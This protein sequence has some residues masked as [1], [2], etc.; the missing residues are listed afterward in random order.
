MLKAFYLFSACAIMLLVSCVRD[1]IPCGDP[2]PTLAGIE[3]VDRNDSLLVGTKYDP[4]SVY[5]TVN[6]EILSISVD[7]GIIWISYG[8]PKHYLAQD[9]YLTLS[10]EDTDTLKFNAY[11]VTPEDCST[12]WVFNGLNYNSKDLAPVQGVPLIFKIVK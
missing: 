3:L 8:L 6:N 9:F 10:A 5:L 1:P 2:M 11:A 4:D 7:R 12:Y